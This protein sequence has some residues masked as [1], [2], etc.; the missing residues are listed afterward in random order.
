MLKLKLQYFGHL[1][2]RAA[3]LEKTLMLG[4]IW[5]QKE[6]GMTKDE[7]VGWHHVQMTWVWVNS[8]SWWWTG[9]LGMLQFMGSQ[10][11]GHNWA[12]EL[13]WS[14][15]LCCFL[16]WGMLN[17]S[18]SWLKL[19]CPESLKL[20]AKEGGIRI[21]CSGNFYCTPLVHLGLEQCFQSLQHF[22]FILFRKNIR[23]FLW[24][25]NMGHLINGLWF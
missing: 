12:T 1:M 21:Y 17:A 22:C 3:S 19:M 10:R 6:K 14:E 18:Y 5:G 16:L 9:R 25:A 8:W 7:M 4:K 24:L 15:T 20:L 13:N 23:Q 2:W 11:V